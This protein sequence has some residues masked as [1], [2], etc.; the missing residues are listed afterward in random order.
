MA[1]I[2]ARDDRAGQVVC[3]T[4]LAGWTLRAAQKA[5]SIDDVIVLVS[6]QNTVS[7]ENQGV[8]LRPTGD[9]AVEDQLLSLL[10]ET[11]EN[12]PDAFVL[13]PARFPTTA[14]QDIDAVVFRL[15]EHDSAMAVTP[16]DSPVYALETSGRIQSL[17]PLR[18][19]RLGVQTG[20]IFAARTEGF[21]TAKKLVFGSVG[22]GQVPWQRSLRIDADTPL[23]LLELFLRETL[24]TEK[25][26][27]LPTK[28]DALIFDFD[29]VFT[30]NRVLV[31]DDGHEA[32]LCSRGDG[33]GFDRI[34]PFGIPTL[35]LS[36]EQ[37]PV[38]TA[39]CRKLKLECL[40]GIDDKLPRLK[41]WLQERNLS[42][43]H[44]IYVGNDINDLQCLEAVG[45]PVVV[46]DAHPEVKVIARIVL[47]QPGGFG[48]IRQLCDMIHKHYTKTAN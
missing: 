2:D 16:F 25:Q 43:E 39:R 15:E 22:Y 31:T 27:L 1:V 41:A 42:L 37:N 23:P 45:C 9:A 38:V 48:A 40:Q 17:D 10:T 21:L 33:M 26:T 44:T 8:M 24:D 4:S 32:V 36:K 20:S 6:Q 29:G 30:D 3:G 7:L 11:R 12:Q 46:G 34:R 19:T 35:V 14:A 13:L 18:D 47:D 5:K 28:I